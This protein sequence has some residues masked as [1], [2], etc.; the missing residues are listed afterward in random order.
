MGN[1]TEDWV[2]EENDYVENLRTNKIERPE[3]IP[4]LTEQ[5]IFDRNT[6]IYGRSKSLHQS[7]NRIQEKEDRN[8]WNF[9][10]QTEAEQQWNMYLQPGDNEQTGEL[11]RHTS[12]L[13]ELSSDDG[14]THDSAA[15][16]ASSSKKDQNTNGQEG[17]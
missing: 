5:Q 2:K 6:A 8:N 13:Y 7:S 1:R 15:V 14:V 17:N 12:N 4:L 11:P 3:S 9:H 10:R 16:G